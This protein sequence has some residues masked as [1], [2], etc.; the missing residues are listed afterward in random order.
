[1]RRLGDNNTW[2]GFKPMPSC[3]PAVLGPHMAE[4]VAKEFAHAGAM[5]IALAV[6]AV[7]PGSGFTFRTHAPQTL[8]FC[9]S[10]LGLHQA[11]AFESNDT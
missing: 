9:A 5:R 8:S 4:F 10:N 3:A 2:P 6:S 7:E 11:L 1:M